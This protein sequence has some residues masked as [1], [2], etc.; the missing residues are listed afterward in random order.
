MH[1]LH[2]Y[3]AV[4]ACTY[5]QCSGS[6]HR[7][8]PYKIIV[9]HCFEVW[10]EKPKPVKLYITIIPVRKLVCFDPGG[11]FGVIPGKFILQKL[12]RDL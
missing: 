8:N 1:Q 6:L 4:L 3:A 12:Q 5:L 7:L 10:C 9:K 2:T 11:N